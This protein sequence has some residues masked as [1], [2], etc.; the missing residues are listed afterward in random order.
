MR[1][2]KKMGSNKVKQNKTLWDLSGKTP[3]QRIAEAK[4]AGETAQK[5]FTAGQMGAIITAIDAEDFGAFVKACNAA[6]IADADMIVHM[7][8]A[9][10][11]SLNS[12]ST[13]P[14]W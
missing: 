6:G 14:C 9:T 5:L 7:W 11:G 12:L 1:E 10:M 3:Q 13:R 2:V 8:D 4:L